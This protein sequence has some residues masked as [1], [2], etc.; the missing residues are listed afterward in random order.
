MR[1]GSLIFGFL[2]L[3]TFVFFQSCLE[4]QCKNELTYT[5]YEPVYL[6]TTDIRIDI[7]ATTPQEMEEPGKMYFYNN[8]VFVNEREEG[9]HIINNEDPTNPISVSFIPIPG[10]VDIAVKGNVLYADSYMDLLAIDIT[11]PTSPN[12]LKRVEDVFSWYT[13]NED[14]G[15]IVEYKKTN[16]TEVQDC[17]DNYYGQEWFFDD[18]N[19][20]VF[21]NDL[22]NSAGIVSPGA[23]QNVGIA[24]SMARF[25]LYDD[26]LYAIDE[27]NLDV[28]DITNITCP[29]ALS[30]IYVG[31]NI[32]T[33]FPHGEN[34]FIGADNGM[35]IFDNSN[36]SAPTQQSL[37]EHARA[38]DPVYVSGDRAFV[39]LR[40][41]TECEGFANQLDIVDISDLN[42]PWLIETHEMQNP[43]GLSVTPS[44][45][46]FLCEGAGGL[47][48]L[49]VTDSNNV[50]QLGALTGFD[51]YDAIA[52]GE[53]HVMVIGKDGF[54]QFDTT[55]PQNVVELSLIQV[56]Q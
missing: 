3:M 42:N 50:I 56:V 38:C 30:S 36:P 34:L 47:K 8:F 19:G 21:V 10:N 15:Y 23:S 6:Q 20:G 49:D 14:Y 11:N 9:I 27:Y 13:Y 18:A 31:W 37:F 5:Y 12:L 4:D 41:G 24:G 55:D 33:I 51:A 17:Y 29:E 48:I 35:Y 28:F 52:L 22:S 53:N 26:Y 46:M 40:D 39:T 1:K 7:T 43:H 44:N 45:K 25:G 54:Y 16:K 32:E 2:T